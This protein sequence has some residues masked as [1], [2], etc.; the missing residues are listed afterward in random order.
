M[1]QKITQNNWNF[2]TVNLIMRAKNCY[3]VVR[4]SGTPYRLVPSQ[5]KTLAP[6]QLCIIRFT[7]FW[8]QGSWISPLPAKNGPRKM[9]WIIRKSATHCLISVKCGTIEHYELFM[10]TKLKECLIK[11][12]LSWLISNCMK[13]EN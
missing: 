13:P 2:W 3:P 7:P 1:I 6:P 8:E 9:C 11:M 5:K 4:F 10:A 12:H